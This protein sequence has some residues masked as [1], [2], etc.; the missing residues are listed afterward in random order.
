MAR[1]ELVRIDEELIKQIKEFARKNEMNF[2][3]ASQELAKLNK[4]KFGKRKITK[5][6]KF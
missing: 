5:E 1:G 3:Q 6:I 4:I 2:R